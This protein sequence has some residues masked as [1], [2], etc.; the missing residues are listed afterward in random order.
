MILGDYFH[1][2]NQ[3]KNEGIDDN[4]YI[5]M[6]NDSIIPIN[7]DLFDKCMHKVETYINEGYEFIGLLASNEIK[8]TIELVWCCNKNTIEWIL[9][10]INNMFQLLTRYYP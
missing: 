1:T 10:Q 6:I 3:F 7:T 8:D 5:L 4:E 2:I 9:I